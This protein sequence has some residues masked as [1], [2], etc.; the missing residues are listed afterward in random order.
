[1]TLFHRPPAEP[2]WNLSIHPALRSYIIRVRVVFE[3]LSLM[4]RQSLLTTFPNE[5]QVN[6]SILH[7]A[8]LVSSGTQYFLSSFALRLAFPTF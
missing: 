6:L 2:D 3:G 1:M 5:S 4:E 8:Y 7:F